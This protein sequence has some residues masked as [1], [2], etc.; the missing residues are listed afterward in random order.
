MTPEVRAAGGIPVRASGEGVEVLVVHRARYDDWTFPKGKAETD[1]PDELCAVREVEE[2]T[3]L[4]CALEHELPS[5]RYLDSR[6]RPKRVRYWQL[7]VTG[8]T[9]FPR[10][11][12]VDEARWVALEDAAALLTHPRDARL[13]DFLTPRAAG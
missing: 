4:A 13:L 12:E 1:E 3:G 10:E 9:L 8:G 2:E 5:T 11:G 7:R 6:G